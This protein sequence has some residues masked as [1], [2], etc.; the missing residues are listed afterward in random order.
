MK[1]NKIHPNDTPNITNEGR[2]RFY[3]LTIEYDGAL[4]H[5]WQKQSH[6][7]T[8]AETLE[9]V[10]SRLTQETIKIVGAGRTDAGVHAIGQVAHFQTRRLISPLILLRGLNGLLPEDISISSVEEV[11]AHF[12]ARFGVTRKTYSYFIHNSKT[13]S[14]WKRNSA[15]HIRMPLDL[16]KM[17]QAAKMLMGVHDFTSFCAKET[18]AKDYVVTLAQLSIVR[19]KDQIKMTLIASRF[20]RYMVRNIVGL[21]VEVGQGKRAASDMASILEGKDR[22]LA[23]KTAPPHGLFLMKVEYGGTA[24]CEA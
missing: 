7:S 4:Y 3:K 6:Q 2:S 8:V 11:D 14:A 18:D 23:G 9:Q 1:E 16:Q 19:C 21:L 13:R 20:L 17:R 12:H 24:A 15:W 5:G 22:R 10:L